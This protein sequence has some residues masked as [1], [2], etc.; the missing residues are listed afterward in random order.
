MSGNVRIFIRLSTFESRYLPIRI[1]RAKLR[2]DASRSN[3]IGYRTPLLESFGGTQP[4]SDFPKS[5]S[6]RSSSRY[7]SRVTRRSTRCSTGLD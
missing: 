6:S 5:A 2:F 7:P 4:P 3:L 1:P